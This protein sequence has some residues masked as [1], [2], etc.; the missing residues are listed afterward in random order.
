M[1]T[2]L[3][4]MISSMASPQVSRFLHGP[5]T[6]RRRYVICELLSVFGFHDQVKSLFGRFQLKT[7]SLSFYVKYA[8]LHTGKLLANYAV[9]GAGKVALHVR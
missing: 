4:R 5:P 7:I 6:R 1:I 9:K 8:S 2:R 3:M